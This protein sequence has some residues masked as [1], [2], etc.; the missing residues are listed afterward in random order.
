MLS[1]FTANWFWILFVGGMLFMHLGRRGHGGHGGCGGGHASQ[2]DHS[3]REQAR[4]EPSRS[5]K[6][7]GL[8]TATPA[9]SLSKSAKAIAPQ[10]APDPTP[11]YDTSAHHAVGQQTLP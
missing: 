8:S 4:Q 6:V 1:F 2:D 10:A 9:I 11:Q 5:D 3:Q 7:A